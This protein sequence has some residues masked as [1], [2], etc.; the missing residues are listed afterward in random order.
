MAL[1][2]VKANTIAAHHRAVTLVKWVVENRA[3]DERAVKKNN[4]PILNMMLVQT[5]WTC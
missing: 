5:P 1:A 3:R 2:R 4:C